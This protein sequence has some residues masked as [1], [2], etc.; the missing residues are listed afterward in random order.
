METGQSYKEILFNSI[1][2][3]INSKQQKK[4]YF[5]NGNYSIQNFLD[6]KKLVASHIKLYNC[7]T[8]SKYSGCY[9]PFYSI[10]ADWYKKDTVAHKKIVKK[11][12]YSM[13]YST[14]VNLLEGRKQSRREPLLIEEVEFESE[15][16][17]NQLVELLNYSLTDDNNII[18]IGNAHNLQPSSVNLIKK[19]I[20]KVHKK[21]ALVFVYSL[22]SNEKFEAL[23]NLMSYSYNLRYNTKC[24]IEIIKVDSSDEPVSNHVTKVSIGDLDKISD[25]AIYLLSFPD[26]K[27]ALIENLSAI[28]NVN[29]HNEFDSV[30]KRTLFKLAKVSCYSGNYREAHR[31]ATILLK[32]LDVEID[33]DYIARSYLLL[34]ISEYYSNSL[35]SA[36]Y[37]SM[38]TIKIVEKSHSIRYKLLADLII[39]YIK[40]NQNDVTFY[41]K[42]K[43]ELLDAHWD[44]V[45]SLILTFG[46]YLT[47]FLRN[48]ILEPKVILQFCEDGIQLAKKNKNI[49]RLSA[50]YHATG[51][52]HS[53]IG[54]YEETTINYKKSERLKKKIK[55]PYQLSRIYNSIGYN[56][57]VSGEFAKAYKYYID[58]TTLLVN[59]KNYSEICIALYNMAK[60]HFILLDYINTVIHLEDMI[61]IMDLLQ[62][63]NFAF[64][65][66]IN[67]YSF[68][69][70]SHFYS[71]NYLIAWNYMHKITQ[72]S[73]FE[74][75]HLSSPVFW[76]FKYCLSNNEVESQTFFDNAIKFGNSESKQFILISYLLSGDR[77]FNA[78][79]S[80]KALVQ[81]RK[82]Y[83]V[84]QNNTFYSL[85]YSLFNKRL[86]N[87]C[88]D[89]GVPVLKKYNFDIKTII[90]FVREEQNLNEL[91]KKI[92][93]IDFISKFQNMIILNE[94][95]NELIL[96][97]IHLIEYSFSYDIVILIDGE[98]NIHTSH[99]SDAISINPR[100]I[101]RIINDTYKV[102]TLLNEKEIIK[103]GLT[104]KFKSIL[105]VTREADQINKDMDISLIMIS[106]DSKGVMNDDDQR[107][108]TIFLN[109]FSSVLE[110]IAVREALL[111][112]ARIDKLTGINNR[113]EMEKLMDAEYKRVLR[114][115]KNP[116]SIFSLLFI[117]LDNFKFYNDTYGHHV[118]DLILVEY[119]KLLKK[120]VREI[121]SIA[122]LGGDEFVIMLPETL[123]QSAVRV[124]ERIFELLASCNY[125]LPEI[126]TILGFLPEIPASNLISC[127]IGITDVIPVKNKTVSDFL[128]IADKALYEAKSK[129]KRGYT[130]F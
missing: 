49:H 60:V 81:W 83:E 89:S 97:S 11:I 92:N 21:L 90:E 44:N 36:L 82:G 20:E 111:R 61:Y 37:Y 6:T 119:A 42:I 48:H 99:V 88:I 59:S 109:Q 25:Q 65:H 103:C 70:I 57:Y 120:A 16:M 95:R 32:M 7:D 128:I 4:I 3:F 96:E 117:D 19:M 73:D 85:Y 74:S 27:N 110:L 86:N 47:A 114:Y 106:K 77:E 100:E 63:E 116:Q 31:Y 50:C 104:G 125:F 102:T 54:N 34:G 93:E 38:L 127:S 69:G 64:Q 113:M 18:Y 115:P 84:A 75:H 68:L 51:V 94:K 78:L 2:S 121:D 53:I 29:Q 67:I 40:T 79:N 72:L 28:E 30:K 14:I 12:C 101:Y 105:Y 35:E 107:V 33:I 71:G 39:F 124:A 41:L 58:A 52:I 123:K 76:L 10:I 108:L 15:M 17:L 91:Q 87:Q 66:R 23:D 98:K 55:N 9:E 26:A 112:A 13:H 45:T 118:G 122:R 22:P 46:G 8:F 129:G 1:F 126:E 62:I 24:S 43:E 80:E 130:V 56:Y 5:I